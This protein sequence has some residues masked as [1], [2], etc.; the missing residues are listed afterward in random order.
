MTKFRLCS[1]QKGAQMKYRENIKPVSFLKAHAFEIIRALSKSKKTMIIT[2]NGEAKAVIQDI[3]LYEQNQET[4]SLL[5]ILAQSSES[6]K[7]GL[8]KPVSKALYNIESR[9]DQTRSK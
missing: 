3:K 9:I 7:R 2:Q 6:I 1:E 4:L 8:A 5:K